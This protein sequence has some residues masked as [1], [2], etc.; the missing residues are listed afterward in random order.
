MDKLKVI[1]AYRRGFITM[2]ECA[3]ILGIDSPKILGIMDDSD[4][5]VTPPP[6]ALKRE[7]GR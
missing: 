2:K 6:L 3:Q 7:P 5:E 4:R 1:M